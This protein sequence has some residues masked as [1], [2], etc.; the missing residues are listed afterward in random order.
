[1][2]KVQDQARSVRLYRGAVHAMSSMMAPLRRR[3]I[4]R[5]S[6]VSWETGLRR[7]L[8]ES[9]ASGF[10]SARKTLAKLP[11]ALGAK[12]AVCDTP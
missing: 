4:V 1:M 5:T 10:A 6:R 7:P 9:I 11:A 2:R 12:L 8:R 3:G